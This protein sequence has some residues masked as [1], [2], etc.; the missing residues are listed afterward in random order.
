MTNDYYLDPR[1]AAGYDEDMGA[2]ADAMGDVPFYVELARQAA[3]DGHTVLELGCGTGRVTIPIAKSGVEVVGLDNAAPMLDIARRKAT[4]AGVNVRWIEAD[5]RS[6]EIDQLFG[7]VIIPYRSFMHLLTDEAQASCLRTV[8]AHL[9]LGGRLALNV[10]APPFVS[11]ET[12][13]TSPIISKIHKLMS[14]RYVSR[15]E[16]QTLLEAAG[17]EVEALYGGFR[18]EAFEDSSTEVVWLAKTISPVK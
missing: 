16:M 11:P 8:R 17:F 5:M 4:A 15:V 3:A 7:L 13:S 18:G 14:L 9:V 2:E 6:F 1:L 12:G 10:F